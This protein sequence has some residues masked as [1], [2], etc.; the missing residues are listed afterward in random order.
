MGVDFVVNLDNPKEKAD[1]IASLDQYHGTH[2][3]YMKKKS[4]IRSDNMN[5][6]YWGVVIGYICEE[7]GMLPLEVHDFFKK[8]FL[9]MVNWGENQYDLTTTSK[10]NA[11]MWEYIEY[12]RSWANMFLFKKL[13]KNGIGEIPDPKS[14]LR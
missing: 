9:W 6:Y 7:T 12:I 8:K 10:T 4:K 2:I 14:V 11:E 13:K 3:F 5:A 1:F